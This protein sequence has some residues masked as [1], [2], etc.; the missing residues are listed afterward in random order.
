MSDRNFTALNGVIV[1]PYSDGVINVGGSHIAREHVEALLEFFAHEAKI[2][3]PKPWLMAKEGEVWVLFQ[4]GDT[5]GTPWVRLTN[6]E[7][8][9]C[10]AYYNPRIVPAD[11]FVHGFPL[12]RVER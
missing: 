11:C 12:W 4:K 9:A 7:W 8:R 2:N 6:G 1:H 5:N 10:E 3:T